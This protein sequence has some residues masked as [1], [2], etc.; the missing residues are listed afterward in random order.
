MA[1]LSNINNRFIVS[2]AGHVSIGNVT[3]NTYLVHAKS[4]GINNA[5]LALE[6]SSWSAGASAELRLSYVAGHERSIKGGY[7]TG[8]EFYTNNATPAIAILPGGSASGATGNVG[9]GTDSP[10][11]RLETKAANTGATTDYS[12][13]VIKA[14]A[15]LIGGYTGTKIISLL[16]GFDGGIHAVDFGYGYNTVGYDIMLSTNDNTTGDPI[17][18]MRITSGA[19]INMDVMAGQASE[20]II[21]IG[22]Y[23]VN[24]SRYNE[25]QNSVT[26]TG[27]G[28]YMNLSVHS[29]TENVVTDVMTLLGSGNVGIGGG[30]INSPT[31][32]G[33]FLNI[34]GRN[35]IGAGTAGIVL[36]DYDN[37]AWDIWNSGGILNFRYNNGASGAGNG[38]SIDTT[39]NAT[40][41]GSAL[42]DGLASDGYRI[43]K[44][45]LQAPY[46]GGWGS[47][48][49][50][51]VIGGLQQTN[52]RSDIGASNIAA[53]ID[54][55]LENNTYGTGQTRI[56]FKCG[57]VNGVDS[58]EKMRIN[59]E[60]C[61]YNVNSYTSTFFGLDTGNIANQT[62]VHNAGF[63]HKA[64]EDMTTGAYN[65]GLGAF[66][67]ENNTTGDENT[68]VG[69]AALYNGI[70]VGNKNT[71]VGS[72]ALGK[73]TTGY[74]NI[75][76]G[77][78]SGQNL[79]TGN[80]NVSVGT[81]AGYNNVDGIH[82]TYIGTAAGYTS[83]GQ[84]YNTCV[85]YEAGFYNTGNGTVLIGRFAGRDNTADYT[86]AVG[87]NAALYN[88]TGTQNT[89]VGFHALINFKTSGFNTAVGYNCMGGGS[90][91][92][93]GNTGTQNTMMG[94]YTGHSITTGNN[95]SGFGMEAL[96]AVTT[97]LSNTAVG[98]YA[99]QLL[100]T[101][102]FNVAIGQQALRNSING[103]HNT[104]VG[105]QSGY[106]VTSGY[107][108][109]L[110]GYLAGDNITTGNNNICLG[111]LADPPSNSST[112]T[113]VLG[114]SAIQSLRCQVQTI[115]SL[116]DKRDKTNIK[117]SEYGL[118]LINSLRPVTFD[119][120]QRDG[121][122]KGLKDLG[123]IAQDLQKVD[124]EHLSFVSDEDPEKLSASYGRLIPV[125]VKAIQELKAEIE[126]LKNK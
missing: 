117:D 62:G 85:G 58:T 92:S 115:S 126:L 81:N 84:N 55:E 69:Y 98:F 67:L 90:A 19:R 53:A 47:I 16:S 123:F 89:A 74:Q 17:E 24:T 30:A 50:G 114:N 110:I 111:Y 91:S 66:A 49:P 14:T 11:A 71:A 43:Y 107:R 116:S 59:S 31:S 21:R 124:D 118:D 106:L 28:S 5:I 39:S 51:T 27:A 101:G 105:F 10:G 97:G 9:I 79:T 60:G 12:T 120:N 6:S 20:G 99:S 1:N 93:G 61:I 77:A 96:Y 7:A 75:G 33:T 36:K 112:N 8:L 80:N 76:I 32:V 83:P 94:R 103:Y 46:T 34:T 29:G 25:I 125:L 56:S 48:T 2:D 102:N 86:V 41:A 64:L 63:G 37:A 45:R 73:V 88:T 109:T 78:G 44:I 3:T 15:P 119:W 18:R 38:L 87:Y 113:I 42:L 23:D 82:N 65:T 52:Y 54:F 35:G 4:S 95:N 108:N 70:A 121:K 122:R 68:A 26:S 72:I 13:K 100:Q 22:R 40:L 57:G 104:A